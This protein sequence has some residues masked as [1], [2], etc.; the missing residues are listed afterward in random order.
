MPFKNPIGLYALISLLILLI[1]YFFAR[2][3]L[4]KIYPSIMFFLK[5]GQVKK[6]TAFFR[7]IMANLLFFL[8]FI[9]IGLLALAIA[10]PFVNIPQNVSQSHVMII[11]DT[12]ASM[13]AGMGSST[14]FEEAVK[15]ARSQIKDKEKVS[16][17][18]DYCF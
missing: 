8:Q 4:K 1:I 12:S 5:E 18:L 9:A 6:R 10:S 2:R 16:I 15:E 17:L 11:M 7:K 3:P 13:Q 14:R